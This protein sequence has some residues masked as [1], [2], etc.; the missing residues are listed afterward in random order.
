MR[1][2]GY[3]GAAML[4]FL[5]LIQSQ[6]AIAST[7]AIC[8]NI[9]HD[10]LPYTICE[11]Q[12]GADLRLWLRGA[13]GLPLGSFA[14]VEAGLNGARLSFAM[15]AGMYHTD[16]RPVGL[17]IENGEQEGPL[18]DGGG[19]GNFGLLPNGVFCISETLRV[20]ERTAFIAENPTCRYAS[21]SGPMLVIN[22]ALHPRFRPDSTSRN[23][24]NGVGTSADGS[25]AVFAIANRPV[26]FFEFARLFQSHL[27]LPDALFF[28]GKVSRLYAPMLGRSDLGLP[29]GPIVGLVDET[30]VAR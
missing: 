25:R 12:A 7:A 13:D 29:M 1:R 6:A 16:R 19:Y 20:F 3:V 11:V 10:N 23:I 24:R 4:A 30:T 8:K 17:Y 2:T 26:T 15:N 22:G 14:A 28:D 27:G 9:S 18:S 5:T 21:Q